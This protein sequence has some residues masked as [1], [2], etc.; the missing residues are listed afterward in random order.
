MRVRDE[1]TPLIQW[2]GI[3][4]WP[5]DTNNDPL[6]P[7]C[8]NGRISPVALVPSPPNNPTESERFDS[9]ERSARAVAPA[10]SRA[11][12][13]A[14]AEDTSPAR[15]ASLSPGSAAAPVETK[16]PARAP[17]TAREGACATARNLLASSRRLFT[18][19]RWHQSAAAPFFFF[20][21]FFAASSAFAFIASSSFAS[22]ALSHVS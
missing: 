18:A 3:H 9:A 4:G 14:L 19:K 16:L 12:F 2:T 11:V 10:P 22:C 8:L 7:V 17:A 15:A 1:L 6:A 21:G 13:G 20:P 5:C